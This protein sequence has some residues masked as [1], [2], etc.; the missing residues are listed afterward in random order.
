MYVGLHENHFFY[1]QNR[2]AFP[3]SYRCSHC[4]E[5]WKTAWHQQ[6]HEWGCN[7]QVRYT[8]RGGWY[9]LNA[10]MADEL[11]NEGFV[12][13]DTLRFP[14]FLPSTITRVGWNVFQNRV[15]TKKKNNNKAVRFN[16]R[17]RQSDCTG[18]TNTYP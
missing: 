11:E 18:Y 2:D 14:R 15:P 8:F 13:P 7:Q 4:G 17:H 6:G 1:I 9:R 16:F 10:T 5:L 12:V 3:K